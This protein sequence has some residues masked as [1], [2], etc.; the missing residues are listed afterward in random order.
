[1]N[2]SIINQLREILGNENLFDSIEKRI[3]YVSDASRLTGSIPDAVARPTTTDQVS[4]ILRAA[5]S[6]RTPVYSRGAGSGLTGGAVPVRGGIVL[7]LELMNK[8]LA[9]DVDN[10]TALVQPGVVTADL[11]QRVQ[12]LG[13]FYPPD[14]ASSD[15]C[16]IGGNVAENSGGLRGAKYGSTREYVMALEVVLADGEIIRIGSGAPKSVTG[17]DLVRLFVGSE[18]TL[19]VFTEILLRLIPLPEHVET[20]LANFPKAAQA[21]AAVCA[22]FAN[23]ITPRAA[24]LM[25]EGAVECVRRYKASSAL[26][27]SGVFCLFEVDG[28]RPATIGDAD[29]VVEI[30]KSNGATLVKKAAND[31][32]REHYWQLRRAI[33]PA[34]YTLGRVK[35]NEDICVPRTRLA[36]MLDKTQEIGRRCL[37]RIVNFGHIGDGSIH[38][39]VMLERDDEELSRKAEQAVAEIFAAAVSMG[40]TLSSEHGIGLTKARFLGIE[41]PEKEFSLMAR[42]KNLLD[43]N[44]ILNP[45]KFLDVGR[46]EKP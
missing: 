41:L 15:F 27:A 28:P 24:E 31:Q 37:L 9:I 8:I 17:Y 46:P 42:I 2:T 13:L 22:M 25:D 38:V 36:E 12:R 23:R 29:R 33:S 21:A 1:M 34:L 14:P 45:G 6:A 19:G 7:D 43:P 11:Q 35:L 5:N 16:T 18:G 30:C 40:G 4:R 32:E 20:V 39:N 44:G 3:A 26:P 10:M